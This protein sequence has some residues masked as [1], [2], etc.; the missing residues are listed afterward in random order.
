[1]AEEKITQEA[2]PETE[3]GSKSAWQAQKEEWYDQIP[4]TLK[5]LDWIVGICLTL[6]GLC[7]LAIIL[8]ATGIC[9]F[10]G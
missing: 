3:S 1:M 2:T 8:D 5:Q 7:F 4:L 9:N 10:F 6:L